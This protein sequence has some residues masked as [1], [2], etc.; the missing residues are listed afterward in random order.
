MVEVIRAKQAVTYFQ[1]VLAAACLGLAIMAHPGSVFSL[2]AA[3]AAILRFRHLFPI[4]HIAL[5]AL[6]VC[7]LGLPW[8]TYQKFVD[9]PG[10]RLLKMHLAGDVFV[11]N[12]STWQAIR[13]AY[14]SKSAGDIARFK[15]SNIRLLGGRKPL[16]T[17]GLG[18]V[19]VTGGLHIDH[20][21]AESSRIAQR[22][23]IWNAV[24][25]LNVGWLPAMILFLR[26]KN[27][28]PAIPFSGWMI[29]AALGNLVFWA[30]VTFGP[31][32]TVTT[33]SSYADILVLSIGLLGFL[34]T[35]PRFVCV[36]LLVLQVFNLF[37]VWVWSP[38][39][40]LPP[41]ANGILAPIP[42]ATL[43][44]LWKFAHLGN[45]LVFRTE[46]SGCFSQDSTHKRSRGAPLTVSCQSS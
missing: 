4:R 28:A 31:N 45:A 36:A 39:H 46:L 3:A 40:A 26:R 15:W 11:D 21:A 2:C 22:E 5:T 14:G 16:D 29:A 6:I 13:N 33:H 30:L 24:G 23:Y 42:S 12:R 8:T 17:F 10:N 37:A 9:P 41:P 43:T 7:L 27:R 35:L 19:S 1:T 32:E 38:P 20:A 34:L 44:R 18:D 25:L